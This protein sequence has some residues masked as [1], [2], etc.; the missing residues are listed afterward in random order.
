MEASTRTGSETEDEKKEWRE[1]RGK[2]GRDEK[3][4]E[5]LRV[6]KRR[7]QREAVGDEI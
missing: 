5:Q 6:R 7:T 1:Y 2:I 3:E 4:R